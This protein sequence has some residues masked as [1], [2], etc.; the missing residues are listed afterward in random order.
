MAE[1][2]PLTLTLNPCPQKGWPLQLHFAHAPKTIDNLSFPPYIY[3]CP[4]PPNWLRLEAT[5]RP[6]G[7]ATGKNPEI[8]RAFFMNGL[9]AP[10][11]R[12]DIMY[13]VFESFEDNAAWE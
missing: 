7:S 1:F 8:L 6:Y 10:R 9:L 12:L 2:F 11:P 5:Y 4:M 13:S 3:T